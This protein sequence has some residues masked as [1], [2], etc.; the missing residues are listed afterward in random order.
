M[1]YV[2]GTHWK[3]I[4]GRPEPFYHI[5]YATSSDG[6]DWKRDGIVCIDYDEFTEGISRPCIIKRDDEYLMFYSFR[7]NSNYRNNSSNSYRIGYAISKDGIAWI[8]KDLQIGIALS[9][10]GWDSQMMA[11]PYVVPFQG[12]MYM[13]YNGNGFGQS[14]F[15]YAVIQ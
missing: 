13:F 9:E 10:S 12:R 4:D 8:R 14:G 2:S 15:G 5:K 6:V 7:N 3:V 11:Y 1:W